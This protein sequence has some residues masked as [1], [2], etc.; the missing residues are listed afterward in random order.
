[1]R[2]RAYPYPSRVSRHDEDKGAL[3]AEAQAA[4]RTAVARFCT[5][6]A[7]R[8]LDNLTLDGRQRL[9]RALVDEIVVLD[10]YVLVV[11]AGPRGWTSSPTEG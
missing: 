4:H 3:V 6:L 9:L 1:M 7:L 5:P 2:R 11:P 10:G 8:G